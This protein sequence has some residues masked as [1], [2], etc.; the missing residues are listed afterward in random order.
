MAT[1][2]HLWLERRT[3][4]RCDYES[5]V[6]GGLVENYKIETDREFIGDIVSRAS[7]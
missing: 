5:F 6:V 2:V 3:V 7:Y 4:G 1:V